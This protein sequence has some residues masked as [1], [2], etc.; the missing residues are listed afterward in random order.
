[1]QSKVKV[2]RN[3]KLQNGFMV[4]A[5]HNS[6]GES[7]LIDRSAVHEYTFNKNI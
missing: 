7:S 6:A 2:R 4:C 1:M 5:A 3:K